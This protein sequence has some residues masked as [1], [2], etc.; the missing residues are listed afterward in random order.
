MTGFELH[1]VDRNASYSENAA[2]TTMVSE[3]LETLIKNK[4]Y[5]IQNE[6]VDLTVCG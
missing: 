3:E 5:I 4:T 1:L 2:P 6:C